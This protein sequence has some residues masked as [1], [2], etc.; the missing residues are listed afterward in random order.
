MLCGSLCLL[1]GSLCNFI[2]YTEF[3]RGIAELHREK[4]I[5][6]QYNVHGFYPLL[7]TNLEI[8]G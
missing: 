3:R 4:K 2:C 8:T 6:C 1:R 5:I 7:F